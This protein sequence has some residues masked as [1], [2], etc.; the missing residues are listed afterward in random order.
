MEIRVAPKE[1]VNSYFGNWDEKASLNL[2]IHQLCS[3][4]PSF[5]IT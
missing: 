1:E 2:F 3:S 4:I 5:I